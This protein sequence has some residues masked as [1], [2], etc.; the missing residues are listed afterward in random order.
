MALFP[1]GSLWGKW[2]LHVHTPCSHVQFYGGDTDDAWEKFICDLESLPE[3]FQVI[4]INDYFFLDGYKKL[5]VY[6]AHGRLQNVEVLPVVELRLDK[7]GGSRGHLERVNF[8]VIF[9]NDISPADIED[10]FLS[11]LEAKYVLDPAHGSIWSARLSRA[12]IADLGTKIIGSVPDAEKVKFGSPLVEGFNNF[13]VQL[14]SVMDLLGRHCFEGKYITAIGKAEWA[15]MSWNDH[16]IAEKK[17]LINTV[18]FVFTSAETPAKAVVGREKLRQEQVNSH[19]LDCSD[20]HRFSNDPDK[21]R[22]GKCCTWVK[23]DPTFAGL[24]H[25]LQEY[26]QRVFLGERPGKLVSLEQNP[27]KYIRRLEIKKTGS[28][29]DDL[30][31]DGTSIELNPG[32]VAIIGKKGSGKSALVDIL[33]VLGSSQNRT[34]GCFLSDRRF[35]QPK[36]GLA[37]DFEATIEWVSGTKRTMNL[38]DPADRLQPETVRYVPQDFFEEICNELAANTVGRFDKELKSVIFSH[39]LEADRLGC[40]DLD[41]LIG[42]KTAV[43]HDG[44]EDLRSDLHRATGQIL[45]IERRLAPEYHEENANRLDAKKAELRAH[46]AAKPSPVAMPGTDGSQPSEILGKLEKAKQGRKVLQDEIVSSKARQVELAKLLQVLDD[47]SKLVDNF[48]EYTESFRQQIDLLLLPSALQFDNIVSVQ[49]DKSALSKLHSKYRSE[50]DVVDS[51]LDT[52]AHNNLYTRSD[53]WLRQITDLTD[54]LNVPG[55]LHQQYLS[56]LNEWELKRAEIVGANDILDTVLYYEKQLDDIGSLPQKLD[57]LH[58]ERRAITKSIHLRIRYCR[59]IYAELYAPVQKIIDENELSKTQFPLSF[60]ATVVDNGFQAGFLNMVNQGA[61]G[62]FCG[63]DEAERTL[64]E[65]LD[66][67]D[68][69]EENEI[70]GFLEQIIHSVNCDRRKEHPPKAKIEAQLKKGFS[71]HDLY[72]YVY[73]LRSLEPRFSLK[74]GNK[75]L[76]ELS[77]GEKG[78]LL[79]VFYLLVDRSNIPLIIDQPDDNL[80]NETIFHE[81]VPTIHSAKQRRQVFIVTHN[82]NIAVVCDADQIIYAQRDKTGENTL[83]YVSGSLEAREM[84]LHVQDVLEGTPKAFGNRGGKYQPA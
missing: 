47:A 31:F 3:E 21:D 79:L 35:N 13:N 34:P 7:F 45:N 30:W 65:M 25:T 59:D 11:G 74:M 52:E 83:T 75:P 61:A 68:F 17:H 80:D 76:N 60:D 84:N 70:E 22:I 23:A 32:L 62:T 15:S 64:S 77:P 8:H 58:Q 24:R 6:K 42:K 63:K 57:A 27:T 19:L 9:S 36:R 54:A 16:S 81:L 48:Q 12:S 28:T 49:L 41:S 56:A 69:N 10:Q 73:S 39:V 5:L 1:Q 38:A 29:T 4:G 40:P 71:P 53:A 18:G 46:D 72:D 33:A 78:T 82:P 26:D 14:D 66:Q 50:R 44:I 67:V 55:K 2:D 20:A 37:K 43:L 51:K